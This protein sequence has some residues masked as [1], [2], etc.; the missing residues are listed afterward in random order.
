MQSENVLNKQ[1]GNFSFD[2]LKLFK[3]FSASIGH[4]KL[5]IAV[6]AVAALGL[7]GFIMDFSRS[8]NVSFTDSGKI[9]SELDIYAKN[10]ELID[11]FLISSKDNQKIGVFRTTAG[12]VS[13]R[14]TS[15][16]I[17]I[18]DL[19]LK[20]VIEDVFDIGQC[21]VWLFKY[22]PIYSLVYL[23]IFLAVMA[24]AGGAIS[25]IA[26]VELARGDK[27]GA[28][29]ALRFSKRKF[30]SLFTAPL[31]PICMIAT[32]GILVLIIGLLGNIPA[33]GEII[34]AILM[35]PAFV[36]GTLMTLIV[37]AA[38][39]GAALMYAIIAYESS[40]SFDVISRTFSY[41]YTRPWHLI[42]YYTVA[43]IYGGICYIFVRFFAFITLSVVYMFLWL[44]L[45]SS[46]ENVP[47]MSKLEVM[48]SKPQFLNLAGST[49]IYQLSSSES[50][51]AFLIRI[52]VSL[53][54][55]IVAAFLISFFFC[56][57]TTVYALMRRTVDN[58]SISDIDLTDNAPH[59][60][61][62][63]QEKDNS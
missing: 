11:A 10:T 63:E 53:V 6:I 12:F 62:I 44:S 51:A 27:M 5:I 17:E 32:L 59:I 8:V 52:S 29:E 35:L 34:T 54:I 40:D 23:L 22:H 47:D 1:F 16:V 14:F 37:I 33:V 4:N 55:G 41:I 9:V 25:R 48:W 39:S 58:V 7:V 3:S 15:V 21:L 26:A 28:L 2:F 60:A 42:F 19:E 20:L 57:S 61:Q 45:R 49:D 56:A 31:L 13:Q 43:V 18:L 46:A 38:L 50:L 36:L 30:F 24:L